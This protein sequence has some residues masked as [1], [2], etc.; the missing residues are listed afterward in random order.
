M[1]ILRFQSYKPRHSAR[2]FEAYYRSR[3]DLHQ[4]PAVEQQ[5]ELLQAALPGAD[6]F[7]AAMASFGHEVV[8]IMHRVPQV[9]AAFARDHGLRP[10]SMDDPASLAEELIAWFEPDVVLERGFGIFSALDLPQVR[11]RH[12]GVRIWASHHGVPNLDP[13]VAQLDLVIVACP[14]FVPIYRQVGVS[15]IAVINNAFSPEFLDVLGARSPDLD[16]AFAGDSGFRGT[17]KL[18]RFEHLEALMAATPMECWLGDFTAHH[19]KN[20][21][22]AR[23]LAR[24]FKQRVATTQRNERQPGVGA[25]YASIS[26]RDSAVTETPRQSLP[27]QFPD[28]VHPGVYGLDMLTI[29][30]RSRIS[31]HMGSDKSGTCAGAY[32]LFE[33]TG[34]GSMLLTDAVE[35]LSR[36]FLPGM[37]VVAFDSVDDLID[38]ARYYLDHEDERQQI[39]RR[40]QQRTLRDHTV[41][42]R[43][44]ELDAV[45]RQLA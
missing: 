1:R 36:S 40:G 39:A 10:H 32:R 9:R 42:A 28:R 33:A 44:G 30:Q 14:N 2:L 26:R 41:R 31:F 45:L 27:E 8:D 5:H 38:K 17:G 35:D 23:S 19:R 21:S 37:E 11:Q 15:E 18:S 6:G 4:R 13:P 24:R 20:A 12:P 43:C 34:V 16:L 25:L 22:W 29:L 7:Q 3:S